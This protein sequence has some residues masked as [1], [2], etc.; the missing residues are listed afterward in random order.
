M[1]L[2]N[3]RKLCNG[4]PVDHRLK[5]FLSSTKQKH[6][7]EVGTHADIIEAFGNTIIRDDETIPTQHEVAFAKWLAKPDMTG[8]VVVALQQPAKSQVFTAD[9]KRVRDECASLA[10]LNKCLEFVESTGGWNTTSVFDAFPFIT[11]NISTEELTDEENSAY[12][13]FISMLEAKRP[14]VLFTCWRIYGHDDL[15]FSGKGVGGTNAIDQLELASGHVIRVVNGFHPSYV[16]N[17]CPNESCFRKLFAMELCKAL[18]ELNEA[19][20][21][22]T[23]MDHLRTTCRQRT[24]Q[25]M[26][27][28]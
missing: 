15:P 22:E 25:L 7:Y 9:L 13:I 6:A 4:V 28:S 18:C 5:R 24:I 20:Q 19:W 8:G 27:G 16:A 11:E 26:K 12:N 23:W 21:E 10:Y 3:D 14:E 2:Q 1:A 17:Y